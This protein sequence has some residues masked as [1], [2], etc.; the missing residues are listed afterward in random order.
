MC[1]C[2][3]IIS[4]SL[5]I[6]SLFCFR[7]LFASSVCCVLFFFYNLYIFMRA[8]SFESLFLLQTIAFVAVDLSVILLLLL[9]LLNFCAR[10]WGLFAPQL[11]K[12]INRVKPARGNSSD[13]RALTFVISD[14]FAHGKSDVQKNTTFSSS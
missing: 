13:S 9:T 12:Q 5:E 7:L 1:V 8:S 10:K 6:D 4:S 14:V 3:I 2:A 11:E